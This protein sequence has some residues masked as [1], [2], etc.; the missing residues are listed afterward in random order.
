MC[1]VSNFI[2]LSTLE[3]FRKL[4]IEIFYGMVLKKP[5]GG[6]GLVWGGG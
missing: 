4:F 3:N 2:L 6:I 1:K 5:T